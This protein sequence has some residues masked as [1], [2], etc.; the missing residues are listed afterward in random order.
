MRFADVADQRVRASDDNSST[1][2]EQKQYKHNATKPRGAR[3]SEQCHCDKRE[4]ENQSKLL[5]FIVE[6]RTNGERSDDQAQRLG[7]SDGAILA[8]SE[9]EPVRE[10]RQNRAEQGCSH[11]INENRDDRSEDQHSVVLGMAELTRSDIHPGSRVVTPE[12]GVQ[13]LKLPQTVGELW[14]VR[15]SSGRT[16]RTVE[17]PENLL[18]RIVVAFAVA[19]G[20]IG[21]GARSGRQQ[22]WIFYEN[23]IRGLAVAHPQFVRPFLVPSNGGF[24][25]TDFD[26]EPIFTSGRNLADGSAT[27]GAWAHAKE[28]RAKI[29]S[30][31]G[32]LDVILRTQ[33]LVRECFHRLFRLFAR[34]VKSLQIR[35]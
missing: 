24:C 18:E 15:L 1:D 3:E 13:N 12:C 23:L 26:D 10:V 31:H 17:P 8:G 16:D 5:A 30:I 27:P 25:P 32:G 29:L 35:A 2:A 19:T 11:P 7:E 21:E 9:M 14:I 4:A 33:W 28:H 20:K 22:R 34:L 6:Q